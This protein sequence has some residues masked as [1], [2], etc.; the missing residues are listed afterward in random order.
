VTA[1]RWWRAGFRG[2]QQR[3]TRRCARRTAAVRLRPELRRGTASSLSVDAWRHDAAPRRLRRSR[4]SVPWRTA[5]P[6]T[7]SRTAWRRRLHLLGLVAAGGAGGR[8]RGGPAAGRRRAPRGSAGLRTSWNHRSTR[9][10]CSP[11]AEEMSVAT[12]VSKLRRRTLPG[13]QPSGCSGWMAGSSL[14]W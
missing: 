5:A 12:A 3:P 1:H 8:S 9:R 14:G 2:P 6:E 7:G 13:M 4:R 10:R 11:E